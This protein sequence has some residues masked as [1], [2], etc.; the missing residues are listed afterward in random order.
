MAHRIR[1]N[2]STPQQAFTNRESCGQAFNLDHGNVR[3]R[4]AKLNKRSSDRCLPPVR[5][6]LL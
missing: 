6:A 3:R 4:A 5:A 1:F 2:Y